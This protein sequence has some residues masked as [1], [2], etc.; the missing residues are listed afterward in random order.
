MKKLEESPSAKPPNETTLRALSLTK[1][2][3]PLR[4]RLQ[5]NQKLCPTD[6]AMV[7]EVNGYLKSRGYHES[8][9]GP[10]KPRSRDEHARSRARPNTHTNNETA[11]K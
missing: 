6:L 7:E 9:A 10:K 5:L 2:P 3:N 11:P 8:A 1:M 4:D